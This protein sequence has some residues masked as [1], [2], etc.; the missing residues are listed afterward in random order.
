MS[1]FVITHAALYLW[2]TG[3]PLIHKALSRLHS[4]ML[5]GRDDL[6][7]FRASEYEF[8]ASELYYVV[9]VDGRMIYERGSVY[10]A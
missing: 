9:F 2:Q 6:G 1:L 8:T 10:N 4:P 7:K 5:K 3:F